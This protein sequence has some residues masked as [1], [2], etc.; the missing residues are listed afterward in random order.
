MLEALTRRYY[1]T[2]SLE[3]FESTTID[4]HP[5]VKASYIDGNKS[6]I[7]VTTFAQYAD[8]VT[9]AA[10]L[11]HF[12]SRFSTQYEFV[13]D[14]Y[15]S[16]PEPLN[17]DEATAQEIRASTRSNQLPAGSTANRRGCKRFW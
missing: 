8:F 9:A 14:F 13:A 12:V 7:V 2:R 6:I 11:S 16:R 10:T 17:E 3:D 15:T 5:F 1:R 4:G